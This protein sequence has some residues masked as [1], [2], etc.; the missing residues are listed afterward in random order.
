[1][2]VRDS[3]VPSKIL[4]RESPPIQLLLFIP[5]IIRLLGL[6]AP[7]KRVASFVGP[8]SPPLSVLEPLWFGSFLKVV[9]F[10]LRRLGLNPESLVV[11]RKEGHISF[12]ALYRNFPLLVSSSDSLPI[13]DLSL[14][15]SLSQ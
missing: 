15:R 1:V 4:D 5:N 6:P 11:V 2:I 9:F 10:A 14:L 7:T 8:N 13:R 12:S 3:S